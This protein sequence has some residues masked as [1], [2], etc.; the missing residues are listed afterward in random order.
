MALNRNLTGIR[1]L[2]HGPG[3]EFFPDKPGRSLKMKN[4]SCCIAAGLPYKQPFLLNC[5]ITS[6]PGCLLNL[7]KIPYQSTLTGL[8]GFCYTFAVSAE[9]VTFPNPAVVFPEVSIFPFLRISTIR[10]CLTEL[11]SFSNDAST[12]P[13]AFSTK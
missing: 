11:S 4:E 1:A 8:R 9:S 10:V 5:H 13:V 12:V 6:F 2:Q 3:T 7:L